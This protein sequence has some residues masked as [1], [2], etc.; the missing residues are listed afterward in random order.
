MGWR[1]CGAARPPAAPAKLDD[2]RV[3]QVRAA[4]EQGAR[5]HGFEA[6]LWTLERVGQVVE[7]VC[8]VRLS[9]AS[10]WR[11]LT[12][13][14]GWSLPGPH[15]TGNPPSNTTRPTKSSVRLRVAGRPT[16]RTARTSAQRPLLEV[17]KCP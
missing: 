17:P 6:D 13:R 7:R 9:R 15:R 1:R 3:E 10:V 14:L 11:L 16:M 5:A 2:A 4:L 8:G 12:A